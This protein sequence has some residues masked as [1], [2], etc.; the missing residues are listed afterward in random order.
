MTDGQHNRNDDGYSRRDFLKKSAA[1]G[2]GI[3]VAGAALTGCTQKLTEP[4]QAV[5]HAPLDKVRIGFVGV[6]LQ[7]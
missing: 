3:S 6:G 1:A 7:G 4:P 2:L 5:K